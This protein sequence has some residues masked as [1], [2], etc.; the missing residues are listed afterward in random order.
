[1]TK[2]RSSSPRS[3]SSSRW[4]SSA[5][6]VSWISTCGHACLELAQEAR[7]DACPHAL[8]RAD[9]QSAGCALCEG[10]EVGLGRLQPGD[11]A[12][13]RAGGAGA[14]RRE[15]DRARPAGALD[16]ALPDDALERGDLLADRRLRVSEPGGRAPEGTLLVDGLEAA[17][18]RSST[19]SHPSAP[20]IEFNHN[21]TCANG[22]ARS[23]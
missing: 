20:M 21:L 12:R 7:E 16:E 17:R 19:P 8:V 4:P 1:M 23:S 10:G 15:R 3:T 6:S 9:P 11:D 13:P 14:G 18:W 2:E 22:Q 5:D